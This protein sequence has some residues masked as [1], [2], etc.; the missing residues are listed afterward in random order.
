MGQ[1]GGWVHIMADRYRGT[2][3]VGVT[4]D[5]PARMMQHRTASSGPSLCLR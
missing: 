1:S 2:L 5:L 4:A 3:Y